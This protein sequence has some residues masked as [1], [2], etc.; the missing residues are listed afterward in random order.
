MINAFYAMNHTPDTPVTF[1]YDESHVWLET[2]DDFPLRTVS[3]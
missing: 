1:L 3:A 2:A